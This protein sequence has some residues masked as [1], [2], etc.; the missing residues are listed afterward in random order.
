MSKKREIDYFTCSIIT[1]PSLT[2]SC[3]KM[4][5][6]LGNRRAYSFVLPR[7]LWRCGVFVYVC[8]CVRV[9]VQS[10]L[11]RNLVSR[12]LTHAWTHTYT[13]TYLT[14]AAR[15]QAVDQNENR[16]LFPSPKTEYILAGHSCS[17]ATKVHRVQMR[18]RIASSIFEWLLYFVENLELW[19]LVSTLCSFFYFNFL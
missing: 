11:H 18:P 9:C 12:K 3:T 15:A 16:E 6:L 1:S 17:L 4:Y 19:W 10:P 7:H 5:P 2:A 13:H 14:H 8:V